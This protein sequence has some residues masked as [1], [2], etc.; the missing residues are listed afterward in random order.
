MPDAKLTDS[1]IRGLRTAKRC[2]DDR[3]GWD[4]NGGAWISNEHGDRYLPRTTALALLARGL[5]DF[6][7]DS[8]Y[9]LI[10]ADG[11]RWLQDHGYIADDGSL[12]EV[13]AD[14]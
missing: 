3:A 5:V 13:T 8:D 4:G 2:Y 6:S 10:T 12:L 1:Q 9:A 14:A 7:H 11:F